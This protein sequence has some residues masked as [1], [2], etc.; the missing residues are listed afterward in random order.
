MKA[1]IMAGGFGTRMRPLT[2]NLPKPMIPMVNRPIMEIIVD[3]LKKHKITDITSVVFYQPEVI[4]DYFQDGTQFDVQ[5]KYK[6]AES[7]L[8]TAGSVKN[9][10]SMIGKERFVVISGDVLTDF[11]LSAAIKFHEDNKAKATMILTR[12]EN[13]LAFGVVITDKAG[14]IERFLEKPTWGEVFS[15]TVNTGI[16]ILDADVLDLIPEK[17]EFDFSKDLFPLMLREKLALFGYI[18]QGYWKDIGNLDQYRWSH[19]DVFAGQVDVKIPG[20][21]LNKIGKEIWAGEGTTIDVTAKL[22]GAV[23]LG[24]NCHIG[25]N[26]EI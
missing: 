13:P 20:S 19:Q 16:Y 12:V 14:R 1:V 21:R 9:C 18:A 11:D 4:A 2:I 3:L 15:D 23:V 6:A 17:T 7:D 22:N 8:G 24:R 5:M 10:Q 25:K 26:A